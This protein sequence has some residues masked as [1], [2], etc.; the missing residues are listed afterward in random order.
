MQPF[1]KCP[2]LHLRPF[3]SSLR[4]RLLSGWRWY[5][6]ALALWLILGALLPA[7]PRAPLGTPQTVQAVQPHICV[8]THF[9]NEVEEWKIQRSLQMVREMGADTIVEFFLWAYIEGVEDRYDWESVDRVVRHAQNQGVRIIARL[10]IVPE[11]A[12]E[13][14]DD[15]PTRLNYLPEESFNDFAEFVADFAA[16]YAGI[17]DHIIIWNEP[18][19]AFEWG[20][21]QVDVAGYVRLLRA[22]YPLAH[23]AN[24]QVVIIAAGLAPTLEAE[25]SANGLN[26]VLYLEAFYEAGASQYFDALAIHT[27]GFTNPPEQPP[28]PHLLNFRRAELLREVMLR[29]NDAE[30]PVFITETGWNDHPRWINAVRPSQRII[31]TL[32]AYEY[33]RENWLWVEKMCVWYFRTPTLTYS[34]P[35]N[36]ALVTPGFQPRP[37]YYALQAYA[38]GWQRS[39]TQWLP[40]PDE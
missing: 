29:H 6:R 3:I 25:G 20:Y 21:S 5:L 24:P 40:P 4:Y 19:L 15:Q 8:H 38:R 30:T 36:Y 27:Y 18:N 23:A 31:Y 9:T 39:D 34:Y 12:R 32:D 10:G 33:V 2:R 11:W 14:E 37:I 13:T 7:A 16:R 26:D 22:V 35:D 17:I 28:A 1:V